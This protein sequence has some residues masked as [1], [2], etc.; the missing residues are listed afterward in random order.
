MGNTGPIINEHI[1]EQVAIEISKQ[2]KEKRYTEMYESMGLHDRIAKQNGEILGL[3]KQIK[4]S[5]DGV[6]EKTYT[7]SEMETTA[8]ALA[9][10]ILLSSKPPDRWYDNIPEQGVLCWCSQDNDDECE[11][12]LVKIDRYAPKELGFYK[13][14]NG[15]SYDAIQPLTNEEIEE[16][17]R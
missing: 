7:Q 2:N 12:Q 5:K 13:R 4:E 14:S 6:S 15:A 1:K 8:R 16:F 10:S 17:K 9:D 11:R 3:R